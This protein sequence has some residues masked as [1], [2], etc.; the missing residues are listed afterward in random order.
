MN[1][2]FIIALVGGVIVM[3]IFWFGIEAIAE[4]IIDRAAMAYPLECREL[5]VTGAECI[6]AVQE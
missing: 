4:K 1:K 3:V 6:A 5:S 2:H